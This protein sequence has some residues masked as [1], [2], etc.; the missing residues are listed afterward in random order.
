[1]LDNPGSDAWLV[2]GD[3]NVILDADEKN[4]GRPFNPTEAMKF[5]QFINKANLIDVRTH[6]FILK[7]VIL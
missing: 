2:G 7:I 1:M 4:G 3:F 6:V 5:G